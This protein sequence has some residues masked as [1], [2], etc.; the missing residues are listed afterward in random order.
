MAIIR[1]RAISVVIPNATLNRNSL[2]Y[3]PISSPDTRSDFE[4]DPG[5]DSD[6]YVEEESDCSDSDLYVEEGSDCSDIDIEPAVGENFSLGSYVEPSGGLDSEEE[7][8]IRNIRHFAAQGPSRP[9]HKGR[10]QEL[11]RRE[12][13]FWEK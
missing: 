1:R 8:I 3:S 4:M 5:S 6:L 11:W 7:E 12:G 9:H 13:E 2:P 10:T